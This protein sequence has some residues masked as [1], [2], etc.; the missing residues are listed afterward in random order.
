MYH[1]KLIGVCVVKNLILITLICTTYF[2]V[3]YYK[4]PNCI[5]LIY[6]TYVF[7]L[8]II[9]KNPN[10]MYFLSLLKF[11]ISLVLCFPLHLLNIPSGDIKLI[12]YLISVNTINQGLTIIFFGLIIILSFLIFNKKTEFPMSISFLSSY[13]AFILFRS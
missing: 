11:L 5:Y 13:I 8:M 2:D 12:V 4:I 7:L 6:F 9:S 10:Y 3:K 1:E